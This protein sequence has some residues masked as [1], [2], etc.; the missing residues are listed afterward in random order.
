MAPLQIGLGTESVGE[1]SKL[2]ESNGYG[3]FGD[4]MHPNGPGE[5]TVGNCGGAGIDCRSF[6]SGRGSAKLFQRGA[7]GENPDDLFESESMFV[8]EFW[9]YLI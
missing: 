3:D 6:C 4:C 1:P 2:G 7:N 5:D 8:V 9:R